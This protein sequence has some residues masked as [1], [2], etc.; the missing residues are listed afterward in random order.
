[1]EENESLCP[2]CNHPLQIFYTEYGK[3]PYSVQCDVCNIKIAGPSIP[4]V[5]KE[6]EEFAFFMKR[7]SNNRTRKNYIYQM[8]FS[9]QK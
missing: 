9:F 3:T 2:L 5:L 6:L 8:D 4:S 1:M 7:K